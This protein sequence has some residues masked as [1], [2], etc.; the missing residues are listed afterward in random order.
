MHLI[1]HNHEPSVSQA[2]S[3]R[4][5]FIVLQAH[6]LFDVLNFL[7]LHDLVVFRL[8]HVQ[9]FTSQWEDTEIVTSHYAETSNSKG[10]GGVSFRQNQSAVFSM[11]GAC[12]VGVWE[13]G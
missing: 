10:F 11:S 7:V 4:I 13:L 5:V 3:V 12:V 1:S 8:S 9:Q 2:R 6:N